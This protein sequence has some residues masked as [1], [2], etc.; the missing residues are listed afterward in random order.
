MFLNRCIVVTLL[1]FMLKYNLPVEG[2]GI[3]EGGFEGGG[4]SPVSLPLY[5][6]LGWATWLG[7]DIGGLSM[8]VGSVLMVVVIAVCMGM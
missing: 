5:E 6:S 1:L 4:E 8:V 7:W 3:F 2:R